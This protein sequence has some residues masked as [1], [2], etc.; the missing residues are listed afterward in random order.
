MLSNGS[1]TGLS[2][3]R[4]NMIDFWLIGFAVMKTQDTL[5][6]NFIE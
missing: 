3:E 4:I 5:S 1:N 6:E 2:F